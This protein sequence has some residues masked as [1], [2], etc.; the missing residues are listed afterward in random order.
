MKQTLNKRMLETKEGLSQ[1]V[2]I[3]KG[4]VIV[5][6][7]VIAIAL[8]IGVIASAREPQDEVSEKTTFQT[9]GY[10]TDVSLETSETVTIAETTANTENNNVLNNVQKPNTHKR[11]TTPISHEGESFATTSINGKTANA[12]VDTSPIAGKKE[13][14]TSFDHTSAIIT[15]TVPNIIDNST[16]KPYYPLYQCSN[17]KNEIVNALKGGKEIY[18]GESDFTYLTNQQQQNV[19]DVLVVGYPNS[20]YGAGNQK[21]FEATYAALMYAAFDVSYMGTDAAVQYAYEQIIS[22]IGLCA[23]QGDINNN[24]R[25]IL[26]DSSTYQLVSMK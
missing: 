18:V 14:T 22:K 15:T 12:N 25:L 10:E 11:N 9:V 4:T 17:P 20:C 1:T 8:S 26:T 16:V 5:I 6:A 21:A 2:Q 23:S 24:V 13:D 3:K 7:V 19:I